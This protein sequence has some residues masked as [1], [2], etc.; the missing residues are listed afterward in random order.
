MKKITGVITI[1]FMT[2]LLVVPATAQM[3]EKGMARGM[4]R[5]LPIRQAAFSK[6]REIRSSLTIEQ[7]DAIQKL[8]NAFLD[9]TLELRN[10][11]EKK[12]IEFRDLLK[13][14]N[15]EKN[16]VMAVRQEFMDLKTILFQ[17][18]FDLRQK[19]REIIKPKKAEG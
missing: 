15:P 6:F 13:S 18:K 11:I 19:L 10:D 9:D 5:G 2:I 1:L 16:K 14:D 4:K 8:R 7:R 12:R 17:K 3:S